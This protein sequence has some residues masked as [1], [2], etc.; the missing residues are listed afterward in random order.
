MEAAYSSETE[1]YAVS[2]T[3]RPLPEQ[4]S[5]WKPKEIYDMGNIW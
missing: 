4:F 5:A 1:T 3:G 2:Q